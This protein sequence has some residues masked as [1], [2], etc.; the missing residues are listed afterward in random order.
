VP[1]E[2]E[3]ELALGVVAALPVETVGPVTI[4]AWGDEGRCL[5]AWRAKGG[6]PGAFFGMNEAGEYEVEFVFQN[7]S[8]K[9]KVLVETKPVRIV[10]RPEDAK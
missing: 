3:R 9:R 4:K 10:S 8:V 5:G 2:L 6:G 7:K 1:N